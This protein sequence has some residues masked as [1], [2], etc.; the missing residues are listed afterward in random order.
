MEKELSD[1]FVLGAG[2]S[3]AVNES[4]P[5]LENLS[6]EVITELT[7]IASFAESPFVIQET[8]YALGNNIEL[9]M[10]EVAPIN[11]TGG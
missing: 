11:R 1:V 2:F 5:T 6:D 9:W 7:N 8:L 4:M 10:T 3:K